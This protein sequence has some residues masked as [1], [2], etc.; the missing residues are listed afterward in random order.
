MRSPHQRL[1]VSPQLAPAP[2]QVQ[3]IRAQLRAHPLVSPALAGCFIPDLADVPD[4]AHH[5]LRPGLDESPAAALRVFHA[6]HCVSVLPVPVPARTP[7]VARPV[8]RR[9][10]ACPYHGRRAAS[11]ARDRAARCPRPAGSDH[12]RNRRIT[13]PPRQERRT[14]RVGAATQPG[15]PGQPGHAIGVRS[16]RTASSRPGRPLDSG[17]SGG[18]P[19]SA[20]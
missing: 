19:A 16:A 17:F 13:C 11:G 4:L 18:R 12:Y 14:A 15:G 1:L 5:R 20:A 6:S 2:C 7:P 9:T 8:G 10:A 3:L